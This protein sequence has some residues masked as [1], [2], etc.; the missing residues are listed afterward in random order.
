MGRK[1][2]AT[3]SQATFVDKESSLFVIENKEFVAMRLPRKLGWL[4]QQL[5]TSFTSSPVMV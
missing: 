3:K 2:A 4:R 5:K 1:K